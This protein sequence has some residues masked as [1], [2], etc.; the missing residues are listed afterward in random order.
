[1][2][3]LYYSE[4]CPFCQKVIKFF[5]DNDIEF[6]PKEVAEMKNY[7][8]LMRLGRVAQ[9]PFLVDTENDRRMYESDTIIDYAKNLKK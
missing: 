4:T 2:L 3:N 7:E 9:V 8:E 6:T 5:R 1:M